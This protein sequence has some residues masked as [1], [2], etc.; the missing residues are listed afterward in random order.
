M[1]VILLSVGWLGKLML[2]IFLLSSFLVD[3]PDGQR[4]EIDFFFFFKMC[5][6]VVSH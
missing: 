1:P 3:F 4:F 5:I 2:Y 6:R